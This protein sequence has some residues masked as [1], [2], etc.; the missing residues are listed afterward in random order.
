MTDTADIRAKAQRVIPETEGTRDPLFLLQIRR[1][2][3]LDEGAYRWD[4][5]NERLVTEDGAEADDAYKSASADFEAVWETDRVFFDRAEAEAWAKARAYNYPSGYRTYSVPVEGPLIAMLAERSVYW[6]GKPYALAQ[7]DA[8]RG[9]GVTHEQALHVLQG[10]VGT[11]DCGDMTL[12]RYIREQADLERRARAL[13]KAL[14]RLGESDEWTEGVVS[15][16]RKQL[17]DALGEERE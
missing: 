16:R 3:C 11:M 9:A 13:C 8:P 6:D 4:S 17:A 7:L 15:D 14:A 2:V 5:D 1:W 12:A 10:M